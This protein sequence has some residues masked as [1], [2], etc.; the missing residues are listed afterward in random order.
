MW[1]LLKNFFYSLKTY[2]DISPDLRMRRRVNQMLS[3]RPR[4]NPD[5]WHQM[6]WQSLNITQALS[7]FVYQ[8]LS[9][10][11]GLDCGRMRPGDRLQA[12]LHLSL[13]CWF[14]W[15]ESLR[16]D[17]FTQFEIDLDEDTNLET[18]ATVEDFMI[19]LDRQLASIKH[20]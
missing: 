4:L 13:V 10:Y 15:Q 14:D 1:H 16:Q 19:F 3:D 9:T 12:D 5:D 6:F 8:S 18:L 20:F 7:H 17:F 11:S 2:P